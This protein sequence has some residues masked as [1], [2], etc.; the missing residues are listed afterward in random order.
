MPPLVVKVCECDKA[1][2]KTLAK[3]VLGFEKQ[4]ALRRFLQVLLPTWDNHRGVYAEV[5]LGGS[6]IN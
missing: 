3:G 2:G 6:V 5:R 1:R 4:V